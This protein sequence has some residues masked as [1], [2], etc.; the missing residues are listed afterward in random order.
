MVTISS[1]IPSGK[2][3]LFLPL[4]ELESLPNKNESATVASPPAN[5]VA[6]LTYPFSTTN[7]FPTEHFPP[8]LLQT[9]ALTSMILMRLEPIRIWMV[10]PQC[11]LMVEPTKVM[12]RT[13]GERVK[14]VLI[15]LDFHLLS[16]KY[17]FSQITKS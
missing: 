17:N 12:T 4:P 14:S 16:Y 8:L 7:N 11:L 10:I 15:P 5:S 1:A 9:M 6:G 3:A 2:P 13:M